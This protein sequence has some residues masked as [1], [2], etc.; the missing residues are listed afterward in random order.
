MTFNNIGTKVGGLLIGLPLLFSACS[1]NAMDDINRDRNN[2]SDVQAKFILADVITSTAV[3]NVGGDI[4][5]Y[6]SAYVEHEV[7][8][9][10]QLYNAERR[11]GEPAAAST[12][13][14]SWVGIYQS[15]KDAK[16]VV[17][18][19]SP[20][21]PQEG[22]NVTL[23]IGQI[24]LAYNLALLTDLYGDAPWSEAGDYT[25]SLTPKLDKQEAIYADVFSY[26]DQAIANLQLGDKHSSGSVGSFDFI[27]GGNAA[28]WTKFA[29]GLK[30]RYTMRLLHRSSDVNGDLQKVID[31]V[32]ESF[33]SASEQAEFNVYDAN[34]LNPLFDFQWSRDGL[35]ASRSLVDKFIERNDPRLRRLFVDAGWE[36]LDAV[37][38]GSDEYELM[39]PNGENEQLQYYYN[40]SIFVYSQLASTQ[41][42][43]Y[44]ELL[45]LK[46]E[47]MARLGVA[48]PEI[49]NVAKEAVVAAIANAEKS[50][51]AAF[52]A[53]TVNQYGGITENTSAITQSEAENYF[54]DEVSPLLASNPLNEIL[55][56]K[57]LAFF[58]ASGE[59]T[60]AYS[61]YRRLLAMGDDDAIEIEN[62]NRFP[63]RLTYG[64]TDVTANQN[65][66]EAFGDGQ[67]IYNTPVW[68]AGGD[69]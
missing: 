50:V 28:S 3:S 68:W 7:G 29:I 11:L 42:L 48:L 6:T 30:A 19:C 67:Y 12:Y 22:N 69:R 25:V 16:K 1:E 47:A 36:Q 9:H 35:G 34:N 56:Q 45:F 32:D 49:E 40:T 10:N 38:T 55:A 31:Y 53:P 65:V 26:L 24:L 66:R 2:P 17:E 58:G 8:V 52:S 43:S 64:N 27:Y 41:L 18:K 61:D 63:L 57:Y 51:V 13:N 46:A 15:L 39:A 14:N 5:T 59:S 21:G 60:E 54:D 33:A 37:E 23:G 4:N 20:G 44:H 62:P